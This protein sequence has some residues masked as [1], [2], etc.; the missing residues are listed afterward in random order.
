MAEVVLGWS[1][2]RQTVLLA[3]TA[4][5][6]GLLIVE[7]LH[8]IDP[9][10]LELLTLFLDQGPTARV[11]T[12]LTCRPEFRAPWGFCAHLTFLTLSRLLPTE[13]EVMVAR[14]VGR[15]ALPP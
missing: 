7:D 13:T 1:A 5:R 10:T 11:L 2:C 12:L 9:S 15:K 8:W 4:Q 14:V 3:L 6:P